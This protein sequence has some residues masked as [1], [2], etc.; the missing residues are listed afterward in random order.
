MQI[1]LKVLVGLIGLLLASLGVRWVF[2]PASIAA[3]LGITLGD[4][5]AFNTA[6]GDLG[7][8][9]IAGALLCA[10]GLVRDDGRWLQS[11]ALVL[12]CVAAGRF[13]GVV[14]DGFT[15]TAGVSIAVELVMLTVLLLAARR[16]SKP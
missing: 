1:A 7:G 10:L 15:P 11:I 3:E 2:A 4:A 13:V 8:L 12:G 9:F 14:A 5:T 16:I 6:R